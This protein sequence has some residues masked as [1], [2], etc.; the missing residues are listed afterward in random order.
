MRRLCVILLAAGCLTPVALAAPRAAGD[1]TLSA[2]SVNGTATII[3]RGAVWGQIDNGTLTVLDK[4]PDVGPAP[5]V[6][7]YTSVQP[8]ATA[9]ALVYTGRNLRFQLGGP[10]H[11]RIDIS[12]RGIDFT[13]VGAGRARF[14]AW[15]SAAVP[16][17]YAV[18]T[19]PWTAAPDQGTVEAGTWVAFPD[20]SATSSP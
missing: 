15:A 9:G 2:S 8:G 5:K 16:G 6:S 13:A 20:D 14:A 1:G 17:T 19:D 18:D 12:G 10:G 3:G 7:G 11:Y 4:D